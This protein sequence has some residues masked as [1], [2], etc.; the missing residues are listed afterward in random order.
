MHLSTL[1]SAQCKRCMLSVLSGKQCIDAMLQ[2]AA[3]GPFWLRAWS[4]LCSG[5]TNKVLYSGMH[6]DATV[7]HQSNSGFVGAYRKGVLLVTL[8]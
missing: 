8:W 2:E 1:Q 7:H 5:S 6:Y 3:S 4:M